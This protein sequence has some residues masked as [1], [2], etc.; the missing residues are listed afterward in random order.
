MADAPAEKVEKVENAQGPVITDPSATYAPPKDAKGPFY[1]WSRFIAER[2]EES[3][4]VR[5]WIMEGDKVSAGDLGIDD[6]QFQEL[7]DEGVVRATEWPV[8]KGSSD[9]PNEHYK[10]EL[11]KAAGQEVE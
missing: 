2:D 3:G 7:V 11:A 8:P 4:I 10:K 6:E 1:A 5:K 9:S